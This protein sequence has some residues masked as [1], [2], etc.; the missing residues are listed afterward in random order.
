MELSSCCFD[1]RD[2]VAFVIHHSCRIL[3]Y[4]CGLL[5]LLHR[6]G[7]ESRGKERKCSFKFPF[8]TDAKGNSS[9]AICVGNGFHVLRNAEYTS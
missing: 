3:E 8:H 7:N 1:Y 9:V 2:V 4:S 6:P 5:I